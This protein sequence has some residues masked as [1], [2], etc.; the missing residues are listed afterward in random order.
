MKLD[1]WTKFKN[2]CVFAK[3]FEDKELCMQ[4]K[5]TKTNGWCYYSKYCE[6]KKKEKLQKE[7]FTL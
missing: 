6:C 4:W 1:V 7:L 3:K 2:E 5:C